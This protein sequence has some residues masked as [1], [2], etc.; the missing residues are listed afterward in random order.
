MTKILKGFN[1]GLSFLVE[2]AMLAALGYWGFHAETNSWMK[3][4]LGIGVPA[5][6]AILWGFFLAPK[7]KRRLHA[8]AGTIVSLG[9]FGL[10]ALALYLAGQPG[11]ALAFAIIA[12]GNR[13]LVFLWKQW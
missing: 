3:W 10:A 7:A 8:S 1:I 13:I 5:F 2:I 4:V 6:V 9:L 11:L 12:L